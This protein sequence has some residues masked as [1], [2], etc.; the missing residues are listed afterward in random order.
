M[1]GRPDAA[2]Y[3]VDTWAGCDDIQAGKIAA[4]GGPDR[5][6]GRF[7]ENMRKAGVADFVRPLRMTSTEA[8]GQFADESLAAVF[9]DADHQYKAVRADIRHWYPKVKKGG[10][11][12][13]HD[14]VPGRPTSMGVVRAVTE[15]FVGKN[16]EIGTIGRTWLHQK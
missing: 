4:L 1:K 5:L 13:G 6:F 15:A 2:L 14:Y 3:A 12:A 8:S 7:V 9:I 10:V 11:I 16:L